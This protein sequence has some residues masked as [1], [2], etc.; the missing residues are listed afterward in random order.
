MHT[1]SKDHRRRAHIDRGGQAFLPQS[2][3]RHIRWEE[4]VLNST[5]Q[6]EGRVAAVRVIHHDCHCG[7]IE[8]LGTPIATLRD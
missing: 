7:S 6:R 8:C 4:A 1:N 3:M 5:L 2:R